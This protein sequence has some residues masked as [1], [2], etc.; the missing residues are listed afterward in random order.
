MIIYIMDSSDYRIIFQLIH[1]E[2]VKNAKSDIFTMLC[3][4]DQL[5]WLKEK[6]K[7]HVWQVWTVTF[8][9]KMT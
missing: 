8:A 5:K 1:T 4:S 7:C 6:S 2:I 3:L 9:L